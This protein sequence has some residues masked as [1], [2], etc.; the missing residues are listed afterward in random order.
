MTVAELIECLKQ[1]DQD[2]LVIMAKDGEGNGFSP[3]ADTGASAYRADSTWSG[4]IGIEELTEARKE[5]GYSE[6][7][8]MDDGVKAF[9]LW[10]TN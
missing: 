4:E 1:T 8:V 2:R 9:V 3:L 10:P 7:D 6:E 5:K